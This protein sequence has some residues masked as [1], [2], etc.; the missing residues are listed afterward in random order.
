MVILSQMYFKVGLGLERKYTYYYFNTKIYYFYKVWN[1]GTHGRA[2]L[3]FWYLH[4]LYHICTLIK[5]MI[6][7]SISIIVNSHFFVQF[8]TSRKY[9][10]KKVKREHHIGPT[11]LW[12]ATT[13]TAVE[14][15]FILSPYHRLYQTSEKN[16]RQV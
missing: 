5:I 13:N 15:T 3:T 7:F 10:N 8:Q 4:F 14:I 16:P 12:D 2:H 11:K 1:W 6:F 9:A